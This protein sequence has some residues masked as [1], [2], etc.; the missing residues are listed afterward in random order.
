MLVPARPMWRFTTFPCFVDHTKHTIWCRH[1]GNYCLICHIKYASN[2]RSGCSFIWFVFYIWHCNRC[3]KLQLYNQLTHAA[4][5]STQAH[6]CTDLCGRG[7]C[8]CRGG[9]ALL[10]APCGCDASVSVSG[11]PAVW[12]RGALRSLVHSTSRL[13]LLS[14]DRQLLL[15]GHY[16]TNTGTMIWLWAWTRVITW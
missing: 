6:I 15:S 10:S 11:K 7:R 12:R 8:E 1:C 4:N 3:L 2:K 16:W 9:S 5:S 13:A 14:T